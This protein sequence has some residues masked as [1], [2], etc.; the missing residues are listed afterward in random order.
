[1]KIRPLSIK[2]IFRLNFTKKKSKMNKEQIEF[3]S[4]LTKSLYF[5]FDE[6]LNIAEINSFLKDVMPYITEIHFVEVVFFNR[7][8][9]KKYYWLSDVIEKCILFY[10]NKI[11]FDTRF[12]FLEIV[13]EQY[14]L[15][16]LKMW[17]RLLFSDFDNYTKKKPIWLELIKLFLGQQYHNKQRQISELVVKQFTKQFRHIGNPNKKAL[18]DKLIDNKLLAKQTKKLLV[19]HHAHIYKYHKMVFVQKKWTDLNDYELEKLIKDS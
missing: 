16:G 5:G 10:G 4:K 19:R 8:R 17:I 18:L 9:D 1:M 12:K 11:A 6:T 14:N 3:C 2:P 15:R 13:F 7:Y